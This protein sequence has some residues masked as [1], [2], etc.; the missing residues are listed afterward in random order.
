[1][2]V[3]LFS[4]TYSAAIK[5]KEPRIPNRESNPRFCPHAGGDAMREAASCPLERINTLLE[6]NRKRKLLSLAGED[7]IY[8]IRI[9]KRSLSFSRSVSLFF[10]QM[11]S[12]SKESFVTR[13]SDHRNCFISALNSAGGGGNLTLNYSSCNRTSTL[14]MSISVIL[15]LLL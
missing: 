15:L 11:Q 13:V 4:I 14:L 12:A 2:C 7:G 6:R 8:L 5:S 1:M 3:S 9:S 10:S